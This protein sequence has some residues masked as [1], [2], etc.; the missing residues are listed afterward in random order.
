M[1]SKDIHSRGGLSMEAMENAVFSLIAE[2]LSGTPGITT[3]K[4]IHSG[5]T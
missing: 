5:G 3:S 1:V 2:G 4:A